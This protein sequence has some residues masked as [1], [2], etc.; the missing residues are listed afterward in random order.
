MKNIKKKIGFVLLMAGLTVAI[1]TPDG[2]RNEVALRFIGIAAFA[3]G[4]WLAEA[5]ESQTKQA[6]ELEGQR[7]EDH[8]P[9]PE[10][11]TAH[12]AG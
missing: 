3:I 9:Y 2:C 10:E 12:P 4:A 11:M 6:E 1:C 5:Y 7:R 8:D